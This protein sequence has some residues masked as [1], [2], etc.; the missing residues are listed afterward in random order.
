MAFVKKKKKEYK[1]DIGQ[2]RYGEKVVSFFFHIAYGN[3][4]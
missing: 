3:K 4:N 1:D 2:W